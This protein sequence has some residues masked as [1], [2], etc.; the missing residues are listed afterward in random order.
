MFSAANFM[1]RYFSESDPRPQICKSVSLRVVEHEMK[2]ALN[3]ERT[4]FQCVQK[5][6]SEGNILTQNIEAAENK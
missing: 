5:Q 1:V 6:H 4:L 3:T 2:S